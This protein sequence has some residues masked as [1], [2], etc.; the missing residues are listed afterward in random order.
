M[1]KVLI[2][3]IISSITA[4]AQ[5]NFF[6]SDGSKLSGNLISIG[7]KLVYY[8]ENDSSQT[9]QIQKT[10]LFLIE[11][12]TGK[13]YLF[14]D[15]AN[16]LNSPNL[17]F[18]NISVK[19]NCLAFQPFDIFFGRVSFVYEHFLKNTKLGI[20]IPLSISFNPFG[21]IYKQRKDSLKNQIKNNEEF[22]LFWGLD[23][24]Y[25][26]GRR[27][28]RKFFIGPR[29]R[30]GTNLFYQKLEGYTIQTQLGWKYSKPEKKI[31]QHLSFGFGFAKIGSPI[32]RININNYIGWLSLNYRLGFKW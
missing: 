23:L 14:S 13:K 8:K 32:M 24:N 27:E 20:A 26:I 29:F 15:K 12:Q 31:I 10:E 3:F 4:N 2:I 17:K 16:K 7:E 11:T 30:Y 9:Q 1:R 18:D 6:F 25:Y 19:Q 21:T 28:F 5:D 22:N